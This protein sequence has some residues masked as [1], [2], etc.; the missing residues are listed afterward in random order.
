MTFKSICDLSI[1][2]YDKILPNLPRD[3]GIVYGIPRSGM[4]PASIIATAIGA[5]LGILGGMPCFGERKKNIVLPQRMKI[6]LVDDSIHTGKAMLKATQVLGLDE[7]CYYTCAVYVHSKSKHLI[8]YYA[9]VLDNG[10][11]FQWNFSGIKATKDYCWDM[12]GVICTEPAIYDDDGE[13]YR[14]EILNVVKPLL[15]PQVRIKAIVT[16]RMEKWRNDT[17]TWLSKY[18][19]QY[20]QLIMQ[21]FSTATERRQNSTPEE[22]KARHL[23]SLNGTLFIESHDVQAKRIAFLS[24]RPVLSI[25]S[26]QLF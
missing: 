13:N 26:M 6:L 4:L 12:D 1:D 3:I 25:E 23:I 21:P 8:D 17:E 7:S 20:D 11:I 5:E 19:V 14:N 10:R 22:F 16:N 24:K 18:G 9:E 2:I 15:L